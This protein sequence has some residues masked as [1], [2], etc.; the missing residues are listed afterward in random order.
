MS[1]PRGTAPSEAVAPTVRPL[2]PRWPVWLLRGLVL[3]TALLVFVQPV[4]A[5][6]F[7]TG[8]VDMLDLH[9]TGHLA[10]MGTV[11]LQFAA[12]ILLWR[13]GRGRTWPIWATLAMFMIV[14][15]QAGFGYIRDVAIHI[16]GGVLTFGI[17]VAMVMGVW[18]PRISR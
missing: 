7:V 14:E 18:S 5:G 15:M 16:P 10:I 13:P 3:L 17:A 4:T 8:D 12:A 6:L 9:S 1:D 2:A 11:I